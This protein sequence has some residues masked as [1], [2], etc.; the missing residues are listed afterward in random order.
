MNRILFYEWWRSWWA[1]CAHFAHTY[2]ARCPNRLTSFKS[3]FSKLFEQIK[4]LSESESNDLNW[5]FL[6]PLL[7]LILRKKYDLACA[8]YPNKRAK[9]KSC[10]WV[11]FLSS[12]LNKKDYKSYIFLHKTI[13]GSIHS[14]YIDGRKLTLSTN[15]VSIFFFSFGNRDGKIENFVQK[16]NENKLI[17]SIWLECIANAEQCRMNQCNATKYLQWNEIC[18]LW[19]NWYE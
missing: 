13:K 17:I 3:I 9:M 7:L 10:S 8:T 2:W 16:K 6:L 11:I 14:W 5:S 15:F 18:V 12:K 1:M 4:Q 19:L